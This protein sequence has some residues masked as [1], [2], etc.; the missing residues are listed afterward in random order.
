VFA[1]DPFRYIK[2]YWRRAPAVDSHRRSWATS[3]L[4]LRDKRR[5]ENS[6]TRLANS[7]RARLSICGSAAA[8]GGPSWVAR[9]LE[10]GGPEQSN[11]KPN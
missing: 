2:A 6:T 7:L 8:S 4:Y 11:T 10:P 9:T 5:S 1:G 3:Q